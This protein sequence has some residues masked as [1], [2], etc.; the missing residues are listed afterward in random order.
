[1][2][3]VPYEITLVTGN[4]IIGIKDLDSGQVFRVKNLSKY[5]VGY[6]DREDEEWYK[7]CNKQELFKALPEKL[8]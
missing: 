7:L 1:M 5:Y 4:K 2:N 8:Y 3:L 6:Q